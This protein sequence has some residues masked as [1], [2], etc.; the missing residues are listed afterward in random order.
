MSLS[1]DAK[2]LQR[3]ANHL[4]SN[5][6]SGDDYDIDGFN[7][8]QEASNYVINFN[9]AGLYRIQSNMFLKFIREHLCD[10]DSIRQFIEEDDD[11]DIVDETI[12]AFNRLVDIIDAYRIQSEHIGRELVSVI[13]A[14][15]I[16]PS[17]IHNLYNC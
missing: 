17:M 15:H 3:L 4:L 12:E 5:D 16:I 9:M 6:G 10:E 13:F 2:R 1:R 7:A 8:L 11:N 14:M